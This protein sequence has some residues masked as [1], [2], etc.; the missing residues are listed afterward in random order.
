MI[1]FVN[2][3]PVDSRT[4]NYAL[5]ES[6]HESL[7]KGPLSRSRSF[8]SNCDPAA[9][10]VNVH[11]AKREVRFR[12]EPAVRGFVIRSVLQRLRELGVAGA[13]AAGAAAGGAR[14]PGRS[15][16]LPA[17]CQRI[18]ASDRRD[19]GSRSGP[20]T[21]PLPP[22]DAGAESRA[23]LAAAVPAAARLRG[24]GTPPPRRRAPATRR[25]GARR[26]AFCGLGA[27]QLCAVRD[28]RRGS[29]CSTAARR[30]SACGSSACRSSFASGDGAEPAAAAAG[31]GG[32]RSDRQRAAARP[33][34]I[35]QRARLRDRG[36][37]PEFFPHRSACRPG[38]SR[39]TPSLSCATCSGALREGRLPGKN[40]D[41]AR[42]ELARLAAA[43]A[44]RLPATAGETEL[45]ALVGAALRHALAADEPGGPADLYR[46]EPRRT[47]AAFSEISAARARSWH[48]SCCLARESSRHAARSTTPCRTSCRHRSTRQP[49]L[50]S[51]TAPFV[52]PRPSAAR[53]T[54]QRRPS[55]RRWR[56]CAR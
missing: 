15:P 31:A 50:R 28:A 43:K 13:P 22:A 36:V 5:I 6:Y 47:R 38:W 41:L 34:E 49:R 33:P 54:S 12:S 1:V 14:S 23:G 32:T 39:P 27:R 8:F 25:R 56:S 11:P 2:Q 10:D 19:G 37:R 30:T 9:V 48:G 20:F 21:A 3:R 7:P 18:R 24:S 52:T 29:C 53:S 55:D 42:E 4:L 26:L 51:S 35:S 45:Q 46:V 16:R 40:P 17:P 44:V